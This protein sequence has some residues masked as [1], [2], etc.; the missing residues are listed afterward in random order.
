MQRVS[1]EHPLTK[2]L[3]DFASDLQ[4]LGRS[5]VY[6][7]LIKARNLKLFQECGWN[8]AREITSDQFIAWRARAAIFISQDAQ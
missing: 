6:I 8:F 2:H 1:A 3:E 4:A 5:A 7:R